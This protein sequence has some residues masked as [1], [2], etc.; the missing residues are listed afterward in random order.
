MVL[1][2]G[3]VC[4]DR[5]R[6]VPKLPAPGQYVEIESELV[7]LGG[8]AANTANA[9]HQWG[10][11]IALSGNAVGTSLESDLLWSA[12]RSRQLPTEF[13]RALPIASRT[14]ALSPVCD[15]YVT[16]DRQRTMF[17]N[18]FGRMGLGIALDALPW[19]ACEWFTADPNMGTVARDAVR[20]ATRRGKRLY[21][22]DFFQPDDPIA[23]GAYWQS[24]TDWVG[25]RGNTQRNVRW[26]KDWVAQHGCFAVLSDGPNGFVAGSP[27]V[28]VRHYA[29]FPA[30]EYVDSTGAGDI[31]RAGM[32][33]GL[34]QGR[35][36]RA[37]L[38][39]ASA[40]GCLKCAYVGATSR[41]PSR[42]EITALIQ[43]N[44]DVAPGSIPLP[45]AA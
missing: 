45:G 36:I 30:P 19:D 34:T 43:E 39:F 40:A 24:S 2:F 29:P 3:T 26:V 16:P 38:A 28:P 44:A 23:P 18:G 4:L 41:V 21:L 42:A 33:F 17:G 12:L 6:R 20:E 25:E 1:V 27:E 13:L 11:P 14:M 35:E 31:F 9:L 8:E 15:V 22:M 7:L 10:V 32:L 5:V 37:C